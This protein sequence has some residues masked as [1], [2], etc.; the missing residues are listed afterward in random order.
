MMTINTLAW[1]TD[2]HI[3]FLKLEKRVEFYQTVKNTAADAILITGDIAEAH[4]ICDL[5]CE[6]LKHTGMPIYFILG[7]HDYYHGSV[8]KGRSEITAL[9]QKNTHLIWLGGSEP[10]KLQNNT[11][12]VGHDTWADARYG[13]F[14]HSPV[15]LNDSRYITDLYQAFLLNKSEL[16][17]QMQALADADADTLKATLAKA[18]FQKPSKIIIAVHVPPFIEVCM[19]LGKQSDKDWLPYF[20]SKTTGDLLR[21]VASK[22]PEINFTVLCGHTHSNAYYKPLG[23]MT[24]EAGNAKCT[25][26]T[27]Q[28][29]MTL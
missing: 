5:L 26:P 11:L 1:L 21:T 12:L 25:K 15:N 10:I 14:D 7:N 13:D 22:N 17:K 6:L 19:H 16:K 4:D 8:K 2:I 20:A 23:N 28:K 29:I 27:I 3:N 24:V 18:T 9:C